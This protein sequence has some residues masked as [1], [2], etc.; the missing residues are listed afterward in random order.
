MI[1]IIIGILGWV[2]GV[3]LLLSGMFTGSA[4]G[5]VLGPGLIA[6]GILSLSLRKMQVGQEYVTA[7]QKAIGPAG[8]Y[9]TVAQC[10][11]LLGIAMRQ[12]A[13]TGQRPTDHFDVLCREWAAY[14]RQL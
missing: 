2:I 6:L 1:L 5:I 10:R 11:E 13:V 12:A 14:Q 8:P 7:A 3:P 9:P 4:V